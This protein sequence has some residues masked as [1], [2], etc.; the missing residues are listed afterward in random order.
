MIKALCICISRCLIS[1]ILLHSIRHA[2]TLMEELVS[3]FPSW[4]C[5]IKLFQ[6]LN[7][8]KV[9]C[10]VLRSK[11]LGLGFRSNLSS[12]SCLWR[13]IS[14]QQARGMIF[15]VFLRKILSCTVKF[16]LG[17]KNPVFKAKVIFQNFVKNGKISKGFKGQHV[18]LAPLP[19]SLRCY[20]CK[21][22]RAKASN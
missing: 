2:I 9:I 22:Y 18:T 17:F 20:P 4:H 12:R 6:S 8:F 5:W 10:L 16:H 3:L 19:R 13:S 1:V 7:F 14:A 15:K 21:K 11:F